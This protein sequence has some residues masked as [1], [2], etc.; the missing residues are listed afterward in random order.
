MTRAYQVF[1]ISHGIFV[2]FVICHRMTMMDALRVQFLRNIHSRTTV[3]SPDGSLLQSRIR[4]VC[5]SYKSNI[6]GEND[7]HNNVDDATKC[8]SDAQS[9]HP[10]SHSLQDGRLKKKLRDGS[11]LTGVVSGQYRDTDHIEMLALL[12]YDFLWA[13]AEHSSA[14]PDHIANMILAAERRGMPTIVRIGY[15]YQNI[16]GHV[17][18]YLVAGAQGILLPQCESREDVERI[19]DA[20]KF[21]PLG[22]RGLAG[23]RWNAW[24][25][26]STSDDSSTNQ[27]SLSKCV[28]EANRNSIIGVLIENQK[29]I[30]ALD[31]IMSVPEL[32]MIFIAPTDLS[33]NMGLH[34][35]I[36]HPEVLKKIEDVG[37]KIERFNNNKKGER[38]KQRQGTIALGTLALNVEDYMYWRENNFQVLV[39]V[40][41]SMF[42][43]GAK[44]FVDGANSYEDTRVKQ[45]IKTEEE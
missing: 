35:Q 38:Q 6:D 41:Q 39:G 33:A 17:Q 24:G 5:Y 22:Q 42:V 37:Q 8:T 2:L 45:P 7:N 23:E 31:E 12:G 15:G 20:V 29:G 4:T 1:H 16:I 14:T 13:D 32:D 11:P 26:A 19:V 10:Y 34:G 21:P 25:L 43:D 40:A 44:L 3:F 27:L 28:E 30:D 18:K 36:R 9:Y